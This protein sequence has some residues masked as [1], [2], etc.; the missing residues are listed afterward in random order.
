[1][2]VLLGLLLGFSFITYGQLVR[3]RRGD[4]LA[5]ATAITETLAAQVDGFLR[6]IESTT[7]AIAQGLAIQNVPL[8]QRGVGPSLHNVQESYGI[9][10]ALFVTDLGGRVVASAAGEGIGLDLSG[11]PYMDA[12]RRGA[13]TVWSDGIRGVQSGQVTIAFGRAI[14]GADGRAQAYLVAAF[15]PPDLMLRLRQTLPPDSRIT[16]IDRRGFILF[17]SVGPDLPLVQRDLSSQPAV[18]RALAGN[19]VRLPGAGLPPT[20]DL[21]YGALVPIETTGWVVAFTRPQAPLEHELQAIAVRQAGGAA[22]A[23]L[24]A[25][26]IFLFVVRRLIRPLEGLAASADA[27][28]RG[29][30]PKLPEIHGPVEVVQLAAGM[31]AMSQA[32]AN[33]EDTLLFLA[34]ASRELSSSLD[35]ETI[36]RNLSHLAVPRVADW[37]VSYLVNE[38]GTVRRL[39][40]AHADPAKLELVRR[41]A[42]QY[43]ANPQHPHPVLQVIATGKSQLMTEIPEAVLRGAARSEEQYELVQELGFKSAMIVPIIN[44]GQSLGAI[45]FASAESGR[46][47]D[48]ADLVVAEGLAHRTALAVTNARMYA[49][50]RSMA[51]TLQRSLLRKQ[52]PQLPAMSVAA[53]YLPARPEVE[54][55]GDWYDVFLLPDTR[56]GMVIGDVAGRGVEAASVMGEL[57]HALRA[58]AMEGHPPGLVLGRLNRLLELKEMATILYLVFDPGA[59]TVRFANA[60]HLPPLIMSPDGHTALLEG[61]SPPLGGSALTEFEEYTAAIIPGSTI[62]L[63]TDGLVEVRGESLDAGLA[64][65]VAVASAHGRDDPE[66][67]LDRIL[68]QVGSAAPADDIALLAVRAAVLNPA[69]LALQLPAVPES[70]PVLRHT[71]GRWLAQAGAGDGDI[72]EISVACAEACTNAIEHAYRAAEAQVNIEARLVDGEVDVTVQDSGQWREPRGEHRGRG[73]I[74]MRGLMDDVQVAR[75]VQGTTVRMRRRLGQEART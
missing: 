14:E 57:Q 23:V 62:I 71:L 24:L 59:W 6:D 65:L 70:L 44:R 19:V 60:G 55:G 8:T 38:D 48:Q 35:D 45:A 5:N 25:G 31:R 54:V 7:L 41:F 69:R 18:R 46:R 2:V 29:D 47:Y 43:P 75:T 22:V 12:L 10:R 21:R 42:G 58:Y 4:E 15:Y 67:L 9:L 56:I 63:F 36:L 64:R 49:Y 66:V 34:E 37:C 73:I 30:R 50:Q 72:Y 61:G 3:Q 27:I 28:A 13:P 51:E 39:E 53:R 26:L 74:L 16:L 11:R 68:A 52:L 40:I 20:T 1:M 32:V 17:T 33:R